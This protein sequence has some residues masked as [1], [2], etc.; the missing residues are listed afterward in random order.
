M[1]GLSDVL[2]LMRLKGCVYFL[3]Q[4]SSPW[5][6]EMGQSPVAQFHLVARGQCWLLRDGEAVQ[7]GT[8]DVVAFPRGGAHALADDPASVRVPGLEVLTAEQAG[9]PLFQE[10]RES[11]NLLCGHFEFDQVLPHP[12]VQELPAVIHL[13]GMERLQ[14]GWL[15]AV[16]S[17]LVQESAADGPGAAAVVDRLAEVLFVQLLRAYIEVAKPSRGFLA[18]VTDARLG[19]G[20]R[21]IHERL[22]TTLT[23]HEI[24]RAAGMSRSSFAE[25]FR[26]VVGVSPMNYLT[27]WRMLKA[28]ELLGPD[29]PVGDVAERVGYRSEAAF[30][31]A[32]T[33]VFGIG[34]GAYRRGRGHQTARSQA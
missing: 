3:R 24:A 6:M 10:G 14:P 30:N 12:L 11:V 25:R 7:L 17:V 21:L 8:G 28:R 29:I 15:D 9:Q 2:R 20:L 34:P 27:R 31:R 23:L 16:T 1:D 18:A 33:R 26:D 22:E 5:G 32:F 13:R 4:F 19:Q